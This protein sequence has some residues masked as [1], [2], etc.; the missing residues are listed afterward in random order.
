MEKSGVQRRRWTGIAGI[1]LASASAQATDYFV[2]KAEA[3]GLPDAEATTVTQLVKSSVQSLGHQ[4]VDSAKDAEFELR[5]RLMK[6]G[7][8]VVLSI[9]KMRD[10]KSV[11]ST[12]LKGAS[13]E[14]LDTVAL[15]VTRA[16]V[17]TKD[18][19]RDASIDDVTATEETAGTRRKTTVAGSFFGIGPQFVQNMNYGS[20]LY[21]FMY[22]RY[23]QLSTVTLKAG[24]EFGFNPEPRS[25]PFY[26]T[27]TLGGAY[28]FSKEDI[29]PFVGLDFG[30]GLSKTAG[31]I[32]TDSEVRGG[33]LIGA[34]AGVGFMRT[35]DVGFEILLKG[36]L[37]ANGNSY[38]TPCAIAL[39]VG[40]NWG[41][42]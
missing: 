41:K 20:M 22:A 16:V 29:S 12:S 30:L 5:P 38:G 6:L 39:L 1:L 35:A 42:K 21:D 14:E 10:G 37:L 40:V 26:M 17:Q 4:A 28:Y 36:S 24:F 2:S 27:G 31:N 9:T 3:P 8:S 7:S 25:T 23:W 33:F 13:M 19:A 15:R 32:F 18:A 34:S 11:Y